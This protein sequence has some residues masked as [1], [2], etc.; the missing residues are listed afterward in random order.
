ML[1]SCLLCRP[2]LN[3]NSKYSKFAE[4]CKFP[5]DQALTT[6]TPAIIDSFCENTQP[7]CL[8]QLLS[9]LN[10]WISHSWQNYNYFSVVSKQL[11]QKSNTVKAQGSAV[12]HNNSKLITLVPNDARE[13][14]QYKSKHRELDSEALM[15]LGPPG[16]VV[17][18]EPRFY[19][20]FGLPPHSPCQTKCRLWNGWSL[21]GL[22]KYWEM[23][24]WLSA[25]VKSTMFPFVLVLYRATY[26][27]ILFFSSFTRCISAKWTR[28]FV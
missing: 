27:C 22:I 16:R 23:M 4:A 6:T 25:S 21:F 1:T 5:P 7:Y 20:S 14:I 2:K 18:Y 19:Q 3:I 26:I 11:S 24:Q 12:E 13:H 10:E 8:N 15:E 28:F 17:Q 9:C